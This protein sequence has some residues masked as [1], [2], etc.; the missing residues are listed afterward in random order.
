[1]WGS[2]GTMIA[3]THLQ[4]WLPDDPRWQ[5]LYKVQAKRLLQE[6]QEHDEFG[7]LWNGD[8]GLAIY[9]NECIKETAQFPTI[10]TF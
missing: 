10:D 9:L 6:L 8:V 2:A 7:F 1:M 5:Q 3:L 4:R